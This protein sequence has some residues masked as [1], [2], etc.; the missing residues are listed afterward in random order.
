MTKKD[1]IL[2][3]LKRELID[4]KNEEVTKILKAYDF[5][6][7]A[8]Q[9]Q[10]RASGEEFITHPLWTATILA[11]MNVDY[12]M[13]IAALLH[14]V[15]EDTPVTMEEL[16]KKFGKNVAN[17]VN[18][19]TKI[20]KLK[21]GKKI[22]IKTETIRKMLLA[23][24]ND[25]KVIIIKFADKIH[26]MRTLQFLPPE[27]RKLIAQE[28]LDIY[29]PLAGK[30]GMQQIKDQLEDLALRWIQPE[31]YKTIHSYFDRTEKDRERTKTLITRELTERLKSSDIPFKI[32]S[33]AKH[34]YS[35][36]K[37]MKK[38]N[39]N[40]DEIFDLYGVRIITDTVE[41]CYQIFGTIHSI[42]Q[43]IPSRFRD[44]IAHPKKNGYRS[45]HTTVVL[46]KRKAVE[47]QIRTE[48]MEEFNEYGVA[49]HWYYKKGELPDTSQLEWLSK[50]KDVHKEEM[51]PE[52]YYKILRDEILRDDIFIFSPKGDIF[53]LPKGATAIDFAYKIHTEIGHRCKGARA[54]GLI[55]PLNKPLK[56]GMV[57]EIITGKNPEPKQSWLSYAVTSQARKKIKSYF[58][59]I[60]KEEEKKEEEKIKVDQPKQIDSSLK[61]KTTEKPINSTMITVS[62]DGENN[63][64]FNFAKCCAPT[65]GSEIIGFISRGRGIIIHRK[66]CHNL[67]Y[68]KEFD[69][70][71]IEVI[72]AVK[73]NNKIYSFNIITSSQE[74]SL[75]MI[76][77]VVQKYNG[78][79]V[80]WSL[81]NNGKT[82]EG[83]FAVEFVSE[84]NISLFLKEIRK[85]PAIGHIE[86]I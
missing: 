13:I 5:A 61:I 83:S 1:E 25:M 22:A 47:I 10:K 75:P 57:V 71:A 26:N 39:K 60:R 80:K 79:I 45:L 70:R 65:P 27:K 35:I 56:N 34:Y 28:T 40:I 74:D 78:K 36:Y 66:D 72:W 20:S 53:E 37:K 19:V 31:V 33:R 62:I 9:G 73:S 59:S 55:W 81:N 3:L 68:I 44:F 4:Y 6:D 14:D 29:A 42:W 15:V 67:K 23:M 7:K 24:I 64:L 17:L 12:E 86:K 48:E 16:E 18:G 63:F 50:L 77:N 2:E 38:Y 8:H 85:I 21:S 84:P 51:T 52:E 46:E 32:K 82:E 54:N 69:K 43:P 11:Q 58:A 76:G 41:N 30:M 49:S